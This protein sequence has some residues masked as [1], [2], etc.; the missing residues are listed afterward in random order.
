[1]ASDIETQKR[2]SVYKLQ[3]ALSMTE[4][5]Q[6]LEL[7][8]MFYTNNRFPHFYLQLAP[9]A[10]VRFRSIKNIWYWLDIKPIKGNCEAE[11][12][13]LARKFNIDP[14]HINIVTVI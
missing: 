5:D 8:K 1:M 11:R 4:E 10:P 13:S 2:L 6:I 9:G 14:Y 7:Y 3:E 12:D